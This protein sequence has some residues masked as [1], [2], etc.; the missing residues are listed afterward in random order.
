[1]N[2]SSLRVMLCLCCSLVI[3]SCEKSVDGAKDNPSQKKDETDISALETFRGLQEIIWDNKNELVFSKPAYDELGRLISFQ[4]YRKQ[5]LKYEYSEEKIVCDEFDADGILHTKRTYSLMDGLIYS[6]VCQYYEKDGTS[7]S[8]TYSYEIEYDGSGRF[9][10][11]IE[12]I[13]WFGKTVTELRWN[14]FGNISESI[15][16]CHT[17]DGEETGNLYVYDYYPTLAKFPNMTF[18]PGLLWRNVTC[19]DAVLVVEGYFGNSMPQNLLKSE[20]CEGRS[21]DYL[22]E[23]DNGNITKVKVCGDD[24]ECKYEYSYTWK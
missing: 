20:V 2:N 17:N 10:R 23:Q 3:V 11:I 13:S 8:D 18:G 7:D 16:I 22:Y 14:L 5:C 6:F 15:T 9:S 1:M 21:T 12:N 4:C 19:I 24:G